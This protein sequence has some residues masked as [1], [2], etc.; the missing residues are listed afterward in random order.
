MISVSGIT[1]DPNS[2]LVYVAGRTAYPAAIPKVLA[3]TPT[4]GKV[5]EVQNEFGNAASFGGI[6]LDDQT[7]T[8]YVGDSSHS[9]VEVFPAQIVPT[10]AA[11]APSGVTDASLVANGHVD[12]AGGGSA[13]NA[14]SNGAPTLAYGEPP[15]PCSQSTPISTAESVFG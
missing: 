14:T 3:V 4:G 1:V 12:P 13:P 15:V 10:V 2:H 11:A 7:G 8:L 9:Q 6:A 5:E